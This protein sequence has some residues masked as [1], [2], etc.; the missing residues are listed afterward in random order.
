[1]VV[2][3]RFVSAGDHDPADGSETTDAGVISRRALLAG[4]V[5]TGALYAVTQALP[6]VAGTGGAAS[7]LSAK[8]AA[9]SFTAS[10]DFVAGTA[11]VNGTTTLPEG[12]PVR[13][14]VQALLN[15]APMPPGAATAVRIVDTKVLANGTFAATPS[16]N[17]ATN[18]NA[19]QFTLTIST[20]AGSDGTCLAGSL[21]TPEPPV[22]PEGPAGP[23]GVIGAAGAPG[24][25]GPGGGS[26][27]GP[28]GPMGPTGVNGFAGPTGPTGLV[29]DT[30]P[31][32][33]TGP[34]G[35]TGIQGSSAFGMTGPTGPTGATLFPASISAFVPAYVA[36][37][38]PGP[39]GSR[40]PTGP[41]GAV[42]DT[43]A[44]DSLAM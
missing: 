26:L 10:F 23:S 29:G 40:G 36:G 30:G 3:R 18:D 24:A 2:D 8:A 14:T 33:A 25:T 9:G 32:G 12:T 31:A 35:P 22:G 16:F 19:N 44:T 4:L 21:V 41:T 6:G 1:M 42:G 34:T 38:A 11:V 20:G 43:G 37:A 7:E 17:G 27:T 39:T 15:G 5:G 13:I 28:T